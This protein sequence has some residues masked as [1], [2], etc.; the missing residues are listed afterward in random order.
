MAFRTYEKIID[1]TRGWKRPL[2]SYT[3]YYKTFNDVRR[4]ISYLVR[5]YGSEN[6]VH[7][8]CKNEND[9]ALVYVRVR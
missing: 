8:P 1:S 4:R 5:E 2:H 9:A 3:R 6:V 7:M